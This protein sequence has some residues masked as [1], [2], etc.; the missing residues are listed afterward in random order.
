MSADDAPPSDARRSKNQFEAVSETPVRLPSGNGR[1]RLKYRA[2]FSAE[3]VDRIAAAVV[4]SPKVSVTRLD[5]NE[6][7]R[8]LDRAL[9]W[10]PTFEAVSRSR[11]AYRTLVKG[12]RHKLPPVK[13]PLSWLLTPHGP[14]SA[15]E[16]LVGEHLAKIF[17]RHFGMPPTARQYQ[18]VRKGGEIVP[19]KLSPYV[20]FVLAVL[21]EAGILIA[22]ETVIIYCKKARKNKLLK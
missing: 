16:W 21:D 5:R 3:A 8:D 11:G 1:G 10:Y 9:F 14:E 22:A 20:V 15:T 12:R 4:S 19:G 2:C 17:K 6:L 13:K 7:R 18:S